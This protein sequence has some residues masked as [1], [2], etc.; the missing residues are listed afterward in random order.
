[1]R[2]VEPT[3]R[4]TVE[5]CACLRPNEVSGVSFVLLKIGANMILR[6]FSDSIPFH[7]RPSANSCGKID[8]GDRAPFDVGQFWNQFTSRCRTRRVDISGCFAVSVTTR[9]SLFNCSPTS[10]PELNDISLVIRTAT[11]AYSSSA[12]R[13]LAS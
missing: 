13:I 5:Q 11:E 10:F 12:A 1:M 3:P 4:Q 8:A 6:A 2:D 7:G 9:F